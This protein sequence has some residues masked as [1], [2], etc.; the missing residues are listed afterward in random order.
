M[1]SVHPPREFPSGELVFTLSCDLMTSVEEQVIW[2]EEEGIVRPGR[3]W[4][5]C[6]VH[7]WVLSADYDVRVGD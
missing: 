1:P 5:M 7:G 6:P 3:H 4:W 2:M